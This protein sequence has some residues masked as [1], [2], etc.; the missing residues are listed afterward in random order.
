MP[1]EVIP[2]PVPVMIPPQRTYVPPPV[3]EV[4]PPITSEPPSVPPPASVPPPQSPV[5]PMNTPQQPQQPAP[6]T[7][8]PVAPR[9]DVPKPDVP[10]VE[11]VPVVVPD[12][13]PQTVPALTL[14]TRT[15][16]PVTGKDVVVEAALIPQELGTT[17][18]LNWGDGSAAETVSAPG[19]GVHRYPAAKMYTVSAST[20]VGGSHLYHE[21]PLDVRRPVAIWYRIAGLMAALAGLSFWVSHLLVPKLSASA[22]WGAPA[23]PEMKLLSREPYLSLSFEPGVGPTEE[24]ITFSKKRR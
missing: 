12:H 23:V 13:A 1:V 7:P 14:T 3:H 15:S 21:I 4:Q 18:Q 2:V 19:W 10:P 20:V 11:V 17:Y 8:A 5:Q 9:S 22:R 6:M 16:R 24:D